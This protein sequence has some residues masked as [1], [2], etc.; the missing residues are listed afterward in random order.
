M[1]CLWARVNTEFI[2]NLAGTAAS[3]GEGE[4]WKN[5]LKTQEGEA[6]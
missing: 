1:V 3:Q 4:M 2:R 5:V 6:P